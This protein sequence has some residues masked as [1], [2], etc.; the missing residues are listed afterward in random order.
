MKYRIVHKPTVALAPYVVE[1][2]SDAGKYW[3]MADAFTTEQR[4]REFCETQIRLS[5]L[6]ERVV[7]EYNQEAL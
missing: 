7:A 5:A 6:P 3:A 2:W 1:R 4:A